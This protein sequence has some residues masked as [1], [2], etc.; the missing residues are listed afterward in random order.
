MRPKWKEKEECW[1]TLMLK[2]KN[3]TENVNLK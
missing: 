1:L 3:V 2:S